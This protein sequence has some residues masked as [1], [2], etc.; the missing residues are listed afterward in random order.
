[1]FHSYIKLPE[2]T[3]QIWSLGGSMVHQP[4]ASIISRS[5]KLPPTPRAK[6]PRATS[7]SVANIYKYVILC[8]HTL[9]LCV[10]I[11][12]YI[13]YIYIY[14]YMCVCNTQIIKLWLQCWICAA[15]LGDAERCQRL[16]LGSRRLLTVLPPRQLSVTVAA[17]D[18]CSQVGQPAIKLSH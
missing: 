3:L 18:A 8:D 12:V 15:L 11:C 14:T 4:C 2:G 5:L 9:M 1:M 16:Q 6:T 13:I 17:P 10:Y 7:N